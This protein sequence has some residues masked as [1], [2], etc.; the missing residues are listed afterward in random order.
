MSL[1]ITTPKKIDFR[2]RSYQIIDTSDEHIFSFGHIISS[3]FVDIIMNIQ[4]DIVSVEDSKMSAN[5]LWLICSTLLII[6]GCAMQQMGGGSQSATPLP[7][8]TSSS[9]QSSSSQSS[10]SMGSSGGLSF[11]SSQPQASGSDDAQG[12]S[13]DSN[14]QATT[15]SSADQSG[16][17]SQQS[18]SGTTSGMESSDT[19]QAGTSQVGMENSNMGSMSSSQ[20]ASSIF[21][22]S[23]GVFD[24]EIAGERIVIASSGEGPGGM[25]GQESADAEA[26]QSGA[27]EGVMESGGMNNGAEIGSSDQNSQDAISQVSDDDADASGEE[28]EE[29]KERIPEDIPM[30]GT[31]EDVIARQI[32]EA[33]IQEDDPLIREA[34]WDEYRKHMGIK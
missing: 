4:G 18:Q 10:G 5:K 27:M 21:N 22:E 7:N 29:A 26:V 20:S 9:S 2:V 34:L 11:P 6:S 15:G 24:K 25:S 1:F 14:N 17:G 23:L 12:G 19:S 8:P 30:D 13:S 32:R 16:T 33:A 31:G 28:V 3:L